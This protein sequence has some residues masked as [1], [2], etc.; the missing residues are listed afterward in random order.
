M[1][2]LKDR[3]V[4]SIHPRRDSNENK[5]NNNTK[6]VSWEEE[7]FHRL[8]GLAE[9]QFDEGEDSEAVR[10]F[11]LEISV[12]E[13]QTSPYQTREPIREDELAELRASI[14]SR[15]VIQPVVVR[16]LAGE[17]EASHKYEL[18]A[19]ERRLRAARLAGLSHIPALIRPLTDQ[20][21]VEI[22]IIENAQREN[23]N[24]IEEANAYKILAEHFR[25]HHADI[26]KI[27]GKN[28]ATISNSLRLLQ[29]QP[30]VIEL[31]RSGELTAGHGR[32]LLMVDG[33]EAQLQLARLAV[34]KALSVRAL[35]NLVS[36]ID[37]SLF[38]D[39]SAEP[40]EDREMQARKRLEDRIGG[41]LGIEK[42]KLSTNAQGKK[43]LTLSFDSE[44]A[45]KRFM[46]KIRE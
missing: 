18:V 10:N 30:E 32:A 43:R 45:W 24:P 22:S 33:A 46:S 13:I 15:G 34:R 7:Y 28:R 39:E 9:G 21:S 41:F 31:L 25:V 12:D 2:N 11:V 8:S 29:L 36:H 3:K 20:E 6:T 35:E 40:E 19:G 17:P 4:L 5:E 42:V 14:L 16:T 1:D 37:E 23:L 38:E 26:A 44:A 27:V